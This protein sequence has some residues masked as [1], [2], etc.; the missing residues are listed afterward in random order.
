MPAEGCSQMDNLTKQLED[1]SMIANKNLYRE[2]NRRVSLNVESATVRGRSN[3]LSWRERGASTT[4]DH[5]VH[6]RSTS[7]GRQITYN[8]KSRSPSGNWRER[9]SSPMQCAGG[10]RRNSSLGRNMNAHSGRHVTLLENPDSNHSR[11]RSVSPIRT[12]KEQAFNNC[13]R[14][15]IEN[16]EPAKMLEELNNGEVEDVNELAFFGH[17]GSDGQTLMMVSCK[18]GRLSIARLLLEEL[19]ADIN[20]QGGL[21]KFNALHYA[22]WHGHPDLAQ[23]LLEHGADYKA[24]NAD[25]ETPMQAAVSRGK[26]VNLQCVTVVEAW[27]NQADN[28]ESNDVSSS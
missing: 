8:T 24:L 23:Y 12:K 4:Y 27:M 2:P 19:N 7:R 28:G 16:C 11:G 26:S 13:R 20:M 10:Q 9:G 22:C 21:G 14:L 6:H 3:S 1:S 15:I 17:S 25:G 18:Y 5:T